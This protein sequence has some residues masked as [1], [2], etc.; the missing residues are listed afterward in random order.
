MRRT[1][2]PRSRF[3]GFTTTGMQTIVKTEELRPDRTRPLVVGIGASA[4]GLE[5][6][7]ALFGT[8]PPNG[9][10]AFVVVVHLDPTHKSLMAE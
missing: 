8:M 9:K 1:T 3:R 5:A 7:K 6:L 2:N 4:G 10:V